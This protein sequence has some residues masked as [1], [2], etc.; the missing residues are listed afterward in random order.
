MFGPLSMGLPLLARTRQSLE[1]HS[2]SRAA[3]NECPTWSGK[4]VMYLVLLAWAK[5]TYA[6]ILAYMWIS[7]YSFIELFMLSDPGEL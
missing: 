1:W 2:T 3:G 6:E 4:C 7:S 5:D